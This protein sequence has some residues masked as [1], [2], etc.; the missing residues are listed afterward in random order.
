MRTQIRLLSIMVSIGLM[1]A[2]SLADKMDLNTHTVV[3]DRLR[4]IIKTLDPSDVS[5]VPSTLRLADLLAERSRLKALA[6]VE[7]NCTNCLKAKEDRIEAVQHYEDVI[8]QLKD[9]QRGHAMSQKAHLHLSLNQISQAEKLQLQITKEGRKRHRGEILGQAHAA[10][11]DIYFQKSEFKKAKAEYEKSLNIEETQQKGLVHYRLAWCLFNLDKVSQAISK[12]EMVLQNPKLTEYKGAEGISQDES[13]KIDVSKDLA[14]FYARTTITHKTLNKVI[15]LSPASHRMENIRYLATEADRLGKKKEAALAWVFYLSNTDQK[16][17]ALEAQ[18]RIMKLKRDTG[19]L[20]GALQL[21]AQIKETWKK[22]GCGDRCDELQGEI[23]QW[24]IN[25]NREEKKIQSTQLTLA[26]GTYSELFPQDEEMLL[27]GATA[28]QQ[29]K[30]YKNAY[31]FFRQ[32]ATVS[33]YNLNKSKN[34]DEEKKKRTEVLNNSLVGEMDMAETLKNSELRMAAYQHYLTLN[35]NGERAYE[36]RYQIAKLHFELKNFEKA[37]NDFRLLAIDEKDKSHQKE[38]VEAAHLALNSLIQIKKDEIIEVWSLDF[39][40]R[41]KAERNEFYKIH[42]KSVLNTVAVKIN[43]KKATASDLTKLKSVSMVDSTPQEKKN[44]YKNMYLLSLHLKNFKEAL[45]AN[46]N[47]LAL[48]DLSQQERQQALQDRIWLAE[49]ELDY[50]EAYQVTKQLAGSMTAEKSLKLIWLAEMAHLK[51]DS[52]EQDFLKLSRNKNLR[53]TVIARRIL[54]QML[55]QKELK[56]H[57]NELSQSPDVLAKLGLEIYSKTNNKQILEDIFKFTS[58]RK[59]QYAGL[60]S[61]LLSYSL[62]QKDIAQISSARLKPQSQTALKKSLEDRIQKL[63]HFETALKNS[64]K[65]RDLIL[66]AIFLNVLKYEYARLHKDLIS[67]PLPRGLNKEQT[68]Q[69]KGLLAQQAQPYLA[70]S[71]KIEEKL[72]VLWGQGEWTD[73]LANNYKAARVEYKAALKEDINHLIRHAPPSKARA[74]QQAL[75]DKFNYPSSL[76]VQQA[77]SNVRKNPFDESPVL[78]LKDLEQQRGND[79]TVTHLEARL[80]QMKGL[81][82]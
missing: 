64:V 43:Q 27:L 12:L 20:N 70:K 79:F 7:Q 76:S 10:L 75:N 36:V 41:F 30:Q 18:V 57:L 15:N 29:R 21:F 51:Q 68:E 63:S 4:Q 73:A 34:T 16:K 52:H 31:E 6:E 1:T 48:K 72:Q 61:R 71:D 67:L 11:G 65:S 59:S 50:K 22:Q 58:V 38:K 19:D 46:L 37:A 74:L 56:K 33:H 47:T 66:Q 54:R 81:F 3:I 35:E 5:K 49:M 80:N 55:P 77:Q 53:A 69:Y 23:R 2:V 32:A 14:S 60:I 9:D 17:D 13:F 62:I 78:K 25:W 8:A 24:I 40:N 39:A 45:H 42:R 82:R 44:L 28:A 26:Y